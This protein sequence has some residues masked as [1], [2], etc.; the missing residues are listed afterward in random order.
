LRLSGRW[1]ERAG[2]AIGGKVKINVCEG[3]S[4]IEPVD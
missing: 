2:F 1:L 4:I 3:R